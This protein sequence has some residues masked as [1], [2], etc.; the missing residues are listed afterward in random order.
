MRTLSL[1]V[2]L[3]VATSACHDGS[4]DPALEAVASRGSE[5]NGSE[6]NGSELNGSELNGSELNGAI[7]DGA[8][9]HNARLEGTIFVGI[10][11]GEEISGDDFLGAEFQGRKADGTPVT[12]RLDDMRTLDEPNE[13][14]NEYLVR[15]KAG[16]N[17]WRPICKTSDGHPDW[18]V[19]LNGRWNS[20][21]GVPNGGSKILD[22]TFSLA[23]SRGAL[24][25]CVRF[26]YK[27]WVSTTLD[28]HHQACVR[29]VRA[30]FCGDGTPY[31]VEGQWINIY[32]AIGVEN[33]TEPWV[34]ESEWNAAGARCF[35]A[36]NRAHAWV[37]CYESKRSDTCGDPSHFS[38]GTLLMTETPPL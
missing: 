14:V 22:G 35:S 28:V 26:G 7:L 36:T 20:Q 32:D 9:I 23:C 12:I 1:L 15:W 5:L 25:K 6:L 10:H 31:T 33:D 24:R 3:G 37:P 29:A 2:L 18:A 16:P 13:D 17:D 21:S 38:T 27:P 30:D 11:R 34:L 8:T 4:A 19:P